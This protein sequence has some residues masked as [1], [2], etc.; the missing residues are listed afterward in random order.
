MPDCSSRHVEPLDGSG[1]I[2]PIMAQSSSPT[3]MPIAASSR[4]TPSQTYQLVVRSVM[5][6]AP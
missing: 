6:H 1:G 2:V 5:R 4:V 3:S